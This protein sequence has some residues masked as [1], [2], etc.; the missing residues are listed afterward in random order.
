[1][2]YVHFRG[3]SLLFAAA[4]LIAAASYFMIRKTCCGEHLGDEQIRELERAAANGNVPAMMRLYIYFDEGEQPEK[5]VAWLRRAADA[6]DA[7]AEFHMFDRLNGSDDPEQKRMAMG[8][9]HRS[10]EHGSSTAQSTLGKLYR[11]GAGV[12]RN[13]ETAESWFRKGA[14]GGDVDA[15]LWLCDRAAAERDIQQ[16]RECTVLQDRAL[17]S[18]HPKSYFASQLQKQRKLIQGILNEQRVR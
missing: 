6:G 14:H 9:L 15:I 18:V 4:L 5:A 2:R 1:M 8:Y 17:A 12:T 11:D 7:R 10:A 13:L 3:I 16:C